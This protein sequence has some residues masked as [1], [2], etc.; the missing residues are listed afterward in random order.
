MGQAHRDN[1]NP[2]HFFAKLPQEIALKIVSLS[3]DNNVLPEENAAE[4]AAPY[5]SK[6]A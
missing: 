3:T 2:S 6:P 4:E 5:F 1:I